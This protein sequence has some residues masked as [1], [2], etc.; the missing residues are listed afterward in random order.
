MA[1]DE[2]HDLESRLARLEEAQAFA[3]RAGDQVGQEV[4]D[5]GRR[6]TELGARL[7]R[8][9]EQLARHTAPA[10]EEGSDQE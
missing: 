3:E 10:E 5:L 6:I 8:I 7:R 2:R 9:E 1:S 4:R